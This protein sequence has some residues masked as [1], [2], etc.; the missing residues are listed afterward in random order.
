[1]SKILA[2]IKK[3]LRRCFTDRR[4]LA[5]LFLPGIVIFVIY[6]LMGTFIS[7]M[8]DPTKTEY[9]VYSL[10]MPTELEALLSPSSMSIK[11]KDA[12]GMDESEI[13]AEI[14]SGDA[15]AYI[16]FDPDFIALSTG[17]GVGNAEIYYSSA[18]TEGPI[19]YQ[20][21]T[22][23]LDAYEDAVANRVDVNM[24][25]GNYD[26]ASE[27]ESS[28][29]IISMILPMLLL[30][31]LWT[32]CMSITAESI[33][34]EKERGT[35]ATILVTPIKRSHFA[36]AKTLSLSIVAFLSSAVSFLGVM[37][38]LPKLIGAGELSITGLYGAG[39][40]LGLFAV[41]VTTVL[42]FNVLLLIIS[43]LSKS[44]REASGYASAFMFVILIFAMT[45]M[46]GSAPTGWWWYMIPVFNSSQCFSGLTS[47]TLPASCLVTT[48]VSNVLWIALGVFV[49]TRLFSS[50][51]VMFSK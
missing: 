31:F 45:G 8:V 16:K 25:G 18:G 26:L 17:G 20:F 28:M 34:G 11:Y 27:E 48:L 50:E 32:G 2:I 29:S 21:F 10:D 4:L 39:T 14:R 37:L 36:L 33:A 22:G 13:F 41:I 24:L 15:H 6:S 51:R 1:M 43:T 47:A 19:L 7:S 12:S 5:S 44:V 40:Y 35:I 23:V 9:T 38:S 49:L 30:M 46:F 42:L 3:D